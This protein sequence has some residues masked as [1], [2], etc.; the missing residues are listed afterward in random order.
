MELRHLRYF[1]AVG[2]D[3]HYGRASRRLGVAQPA[4]SRQIKDLENEIGF[5]LFDRMPRGV[6][7]SAAGELFMADARRILQEVG[8][9][10]ARAARAARGQSGTLR[11]GFAENASWHGVVPDSF[12]RFREQ[13]PDVVLQLQPAASLEQLAA[14][15]SGR[16]DAGFVNFMP[17]ADADLDQ[18][19]VGRQQVELALPKRHPLTRLKKLRLRDLN[20]A[21]FIWFPRWA[22]SAFYD[23]LMHEC[24]LG[25]LKSPRIVQEGLNEATILSLVSTGLGVGWVLGSARWRCPRTVA[26]L[27]VV[28]L[29]MP[30]SLALAWRRDNTS[31]LLARFIDEVRR[32]RA[33]KRLRR[34]VAIRLHKA[35]TVMREMRK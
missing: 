22:S 24:Y 16:L 33:V 7:L 28:N 1:V 31:P 2:E 15:R 8:E 12:R 25:G 26:V 17:K 19:S 34:P 18:L 30:V 10:T 32:M 20:D 11:I 4:L 5:K 6:R 29:N 14:I 9:A 23:R 21:P 13:H 3:Q 27:P 35:P